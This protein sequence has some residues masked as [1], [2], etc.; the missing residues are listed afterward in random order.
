MVLGN[1][2]VPEHPTTLDNSRAKAYCTCSRCGWGL[3]GHFS[4]VC[5]FPFLSPSLGDSLT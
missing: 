2:S 3:F 1:F 5:L 4:L